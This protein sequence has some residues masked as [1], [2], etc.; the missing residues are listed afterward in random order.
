MITLETFSDINDEIVNIRREVFINE[1][2]ISEE[3]EFEGGEENFVHVC[4][5]QKSMLTG[6]LRISV[7]ETFLHIGRVAVK[8]QFR[9]QGVG[10]TIM[11]FA[12]KLGREKNCKFAVLNAQKQAEGFYKSLGYCADGDIF[13]E[14]GIEHVR[15]VKE[16]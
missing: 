7:K 11:F 2:K 9:K 3:E 1:Q 8:K 15:M 10:R 4:A 14:A 12:E 16:L 13:Y 5:Y 6:Y